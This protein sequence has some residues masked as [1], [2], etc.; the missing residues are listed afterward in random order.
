MSQHIREDINQ[1][2]AYQPIPDPAAV[3]RELGLPEMAK[4]DTNE[5][6]YG[7]LPGVLDAAV[8][9]L[10]YV[11]R[12]PDLT[13]VKLISTLASHYGLDPAGIAVGNGSAGLI[14]SLVMGTTR[15]GDEVVYSWRSFEAYPLIASVAGARAVPVPR[16]P[17]YGHDLPAILDAITSRTRLI[18]LCNPSNPTG[19]YLPPQ[20]VEDFLG[21]VPDHVLVVLDEAYH[22]FIS[23]RPET[24]TLATAALRKN[25]VVLRS[26]SKAWGLAGLR[27]GWLYGMPELTQAVRKCILPFSVN[28]LAQAAAV[29]ALREEREML[30][31]AAETA[32]ERDRT[33]AALRTLTPGI[34]LSQGNFLWAPLGE[35]TAAFTEEAKRQGILVRGFPGE[36]AR[37]T[38]G[39]IAQ[40][41][42]LIDRYPTILDRAQRN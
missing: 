15:T 41:D 5:T 29:A 13:P 11:H 38:I 28:S 30:R 2:P 34:P 26:F 35:K 17:G 31:R 12:Y 22:E 24:D 21:Q 25:V 10:E 18:I 27:V 39:T 20:Q 36:G 8:L 7:P 3:A 40:N 9:S 42:F 4:L 19:T 33:A 6:P 32:R 23:P 37:I 16:S 1:L 14:E